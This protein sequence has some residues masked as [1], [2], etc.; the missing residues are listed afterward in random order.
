VKPAVR[1]GGGGLC[2]HRPARSKDGAGFTEGQAADKISGRPVR[3]G[4]FGRKRRL[5]DGEKKP[6]GISG[7]WASGLLAGCRAVMCGK[8]NGYGAWDKSSA[9]G[10]KV[11]PTK[12]WGG[13]RIT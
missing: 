3:D 6:H 7:R 2:R 5:R 12:P 9:Q 1:N 4:S 8:C 13:L 11:S 10:K